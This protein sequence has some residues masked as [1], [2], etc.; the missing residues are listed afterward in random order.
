MMYYAMS[1]AIFL[2]FVSTV[3]G[4]DFNFK[5][6]TWGSDNTGGAITLLMYAAYLYLLQGKNWS[7]RRMAYLAVIGFCL[8]IVSFS[9]SFF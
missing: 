1:L 4:M 8:A 7:G 9:M 5:K 2:L 3:L 6:W